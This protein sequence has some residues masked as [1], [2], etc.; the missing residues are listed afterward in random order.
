[1]S[2]TFDVL[3]YISS[4]KGTFASGIVNGIALYKTLSNKTVEFTYRL[5]IELRQP[6]CEEFVMGDMVFLSGKFCFDAITGN[7]AG[8]V[9]T[10]SK[11]IKY[12]NRIL[13]SWTMVN[14]PKTRP[15][16]SFSA[17]CE[18]IIN[19]GISQVNFSIGDNYEGNEM[20]QHENYLIWL[21]RTT[22]IPHYFVVAYA[23]KLSRWINLKF[24]ENPSLVRL[25]IRHDKYDHADQSRSRFCGG[26]TFLPSIVHTLRD[27]IT[28]FLVHLDLLLF[29]VRTYFQIPLSI[30]K[31]IEKQLC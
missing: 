31:D 13:G 4:Q 3:A 28:P 11:A 5:F 15:S 22:E 14:Y 20:C 29:D 30:S 2:T 12:P 19:N 26:T 1:M 25:V 17:V 8:I 18:S 9:L 27:F 23:H 24:Q 10:V 7:T 6:E 16:V 21:P